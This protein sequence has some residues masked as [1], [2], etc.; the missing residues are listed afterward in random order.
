MLAPMIHR[1]EVL[2][3]QSD[4]V[5]IEL[6]EFETAIEARSACAKH[7]GGVLAWSEP[8]EGLWEAQGIGQWYRIINS[9]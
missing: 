6:S 2:L 8:W 4:H 5:G 9:E 7:E 3:L 1:A